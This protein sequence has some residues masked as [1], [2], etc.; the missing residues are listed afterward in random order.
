MAKRGRPPKYRKDFHPEDYLAQSKNGKTVAQIAAKWDI[1]RSKI[2]TW[3]E[4]HPEFGEAFKR[5]KEMS[6]AWYIDIGQAAMLG[7]LPSGTKFNLGAYVW[8]T[9]NMFRWADRVEQEI[10][11]KPAEITYRVNW[12]DEDDGKNASTTPPDASPKKD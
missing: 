1:A 11:S 7:K 6:E 10:E 12:A 9:K 4:K 5:G 3:A 2:Y 8:L